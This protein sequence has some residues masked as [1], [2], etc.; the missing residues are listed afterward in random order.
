MIRLP[1]VTK[2]PPQAQA[3]LSDFDERSARYEVL[4]RREQPR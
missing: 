2:P 3:V 4:D 1:S